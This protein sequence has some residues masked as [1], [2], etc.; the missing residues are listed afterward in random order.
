[1]AS[2]YRALGLA[3]GQ[4][5]VSLDDSLAIVERAEAG[6]FRIFGVG[7]LLADSL[8]F[9]GAL[10]QRS[11][12]ADLFT[13]IA[14]WTRTPVATALGALT[15][16]ELCSGRFRLGLGPM[17]K[18]W[19]EQWHGVDYSQPVV[20]M[21]E[22]VSAV[23]AACR[24]RA[25][26]PAEH[27]GRLYSFAGYTRP[28][29]TPQRPVPIYLG[30]TRP[31]MTHLAGEIADGLIANAVHSVAWLRDVQLPALEA[32][33]EA[34][35]RA[36][37]GVDVGALVICAIDDDRDG[38][39]ELVRRAISFYFVAPYFRDLLVEH[40]FTRDLEQGQ[41][42]FKAGAREAAARAVSDELVETVALCGTG[43]EV[44]RKLERYVGLVDWLMLS[45]PIGHVPEI[46]RVQMERIV[47]ELSPERTL[48][49]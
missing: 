12:H 47:V 22:F 41:A 44:R 20:R 8:T 42:A 34:A 19:S 15:A 4:P 32:G 18:V 10:T 29:V 17:P 7:D 35:G 24:S 3:L 39:V 13:S 28:S 48:N 37:E 14:G 38:A 25:T 2:A 46:A 33:L 27:A 21:R 36:R 30:A 5:P 16:S 26:A 1:M 40:G 31:G 43:S 49:R 6:G 45:P 11:V 23:R 9:V